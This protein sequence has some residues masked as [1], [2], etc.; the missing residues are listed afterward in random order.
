MSDAIRPGEQLSPG[1]SARLGTLARLGQ[2][3]SCSLDI[4][5]VLAKIVHATREL[6]DVA[7][8]AVWLVQENRG[9]LTLQVREVGET[10]ASY[11]TGTLR[12]DEGATGWVATHREPV[13]IDDVSADPRVVHVDW[14]RQHGLTSFCA[15][16]LV[17]DDTLLGVLALNGRAPFRF[18]AEDLDVLGSL[19]AQ[20]ASAIRIAR[21]FAEATRRRE[22]A[23][24]LSEVA[25]LLPQLVH[26]GQIAQHVADVVRELLGAEA[27]TV[28][29]A[30]PGT[31]DL[32]SLA[33]AG[34]PLAGIDH[35]PRGTGVVGRAVLE[36]R[37]IISA[38]VRTDPRI[39]AIPGASGIRDQGLVARLAVP[40]IVQDRVVGALCAVDVAG[41]VFDNDAV[42]L[43]QTFVAH[44]AVAL[45]V[46]HLLETA[47]RRS[48]ESEALAAAAREMTE[49][50]DVPTVGQRIV[51]RSQALLSA[52]TGRVRLADV[53]GSLRL[54]AWSGRPPVYDVDSRPLPPGV[55]T[56]GR[57]F[58]EGRH[59][60]TADELME[61]A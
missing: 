2:L 31:L 7:E 50:L 5:V 34:R 61:T 20:A 53:N 8:A 3:V 40:L 46:A 24:R 9:D 28:Y 10:M 60:W 52:R 44:A 6:F 17:T 55:G 19:V 16:P 54:I 42:R 18:T 32:D 26:R 47:Q 48:R 12:F 38:D 33:H 58:R 51:E 45:E 21:L 13:I 23:E 11:P 41:R 27:T 49:S 15:L 57:V 37:P 35:V 36:R 29:G 30:R 59:A 22:E 25:R 43:A 39:V 14:H 56:A 4:D 1:H